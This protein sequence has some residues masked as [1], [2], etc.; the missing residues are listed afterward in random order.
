MKIIQTASTGLPVITVE[1][2]CHYLGKLLYFKDGL[3]ITID[4]G[5]AQ[6]EK[7]FTVRL[8]SES[9]S[10]GM[11]FCPFCGAEIKEMDVKR[12]VKRLKGDK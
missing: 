8:C 12:V 5:L 9:E 2:C 3:R 4:C 1:A 10:I 7:R 11:N 6:A